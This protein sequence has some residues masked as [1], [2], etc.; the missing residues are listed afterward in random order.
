MI[1]RRVLVRAHGRL[2]RARLRFPRA[3]DDARD[4]C[5]NHGPD[6]HLTRL[7]RDIQ[8]RA[9]QPVIAEPFP[10]I[11]QRDDFGVRRRVVRA[12]RLVETPADYR[13]VERDHRTDRHFA[14][15]RASS[16]SSSAA[17]I[18]SS[19]IGGLLNSLF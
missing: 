6:A 1:Q 2:D 19:S 12:D 8:R 9:G 13:P 17:L 15:R 11:P 14:G 4:A 7:D 3:V 10:G 18:K 16:A 5:V